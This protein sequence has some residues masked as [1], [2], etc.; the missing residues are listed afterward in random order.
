LKVNGSATPKLEL[1]VKEQAAGPTGATANQ[2]VFLQMN[3]DTDTPYVAQQVNITL[4]LYH[5]VRIVHGTL[6]QPEVT[7]A[8]VYRIGNDINYAQTFNGQQ[9]NVLERSF[10]LF[11]NAQGSLSIAPVGFRGQIEVPSSSSTS[12]STFLRSIQNVSRQSGSL[13]LAVRSIPA[14]YTGK[15]WLPANDLRLSGQWPDENTALKVGGSAGFTIKLIADGLPGEALPENLVES[16]GDGASV[17]PDKADRVTRDIGKKL[18][19][20]L[21]QDYELI[22]S[23]AGEI[24]IPAIT[25]DWWDVDEDKQ[26]QALISPHKLTVAGSGAPPQADNQPV[27]TEI[28]NDNSEPGDVQLEQTPVSNDG[29]PWRWL[30]LVFLLLWLLTLAVWRLSRRKHSPAIQSLKIRSGGSLNALHRACRANDTLLARDELVAWAR[31]K[32]PDASI[33]GLSQIK[34]QAWN[35]QFI[36]EIDR[37]D[38]ALYAKTSQSWSGED[39]WQGLTAEL[40][41]TPDRKQNPDTGLPPLYRKARIS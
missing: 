2:D 18:I 40:K 11:P 23:K 39:L 14:G 4:R 21:E 28:I 16:A 25:V 1:L 33:T 6:S 22:V 29:N 37:L 19:G 38:T 32:W 17:Y 27:T 8:D 41:S 9:Y 3:V 26:K 13:E 36:A 15:Y 20:T 24:E 31:A 7:G 35:T 12:N 5:N 10:A 34:S 30:T